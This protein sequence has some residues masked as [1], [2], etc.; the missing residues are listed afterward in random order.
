MEWY[1]IVGIS[2]GAAALWIALSA[3]FYRV[4]FKR[5][6]DIFFSL[7]ALLALSP[8]LLVT[9]VLV[10]IKL[11]RGVFFKQIRIGRGDREFNILKFRT[12]SDARDEQGNLLADE[13]RLTRFGKFLRKTSIDELP[14]LVNVL[15]GDMSI[16]GPR[17]LLARYLPRYTAEQRRRHEVRPGLS[18][19]ATAKGRNAQSW[20]DQFRGDV[21]YVDHYSFFVDLRSI[22]S[23][24][25]VVLTRKGATGTDG[26]ARGE[27]IGTADPATLQADAKDNFVKL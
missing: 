14:S 2:C 13:M 8:L 4:F 21:W 23:T 10:R 24:V 9:A 15:R 6:Y 25:L 20:E 17:P 22:F 27:F 7:L 18:N 3:L 16:I 11:G 1:V 26:G 19:P 5:F 12:M